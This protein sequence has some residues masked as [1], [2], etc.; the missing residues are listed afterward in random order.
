[1]K[2]GR[3]LRNIALVILGGIS[4]IV[5]VACYAPYDPE[6]G[7]EMYAPYPYPPE[8]A[9]IT[10]HDVDEEITLQDFSGQE[11][12]MTLQKD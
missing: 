9:I 6:P 1:M 3:I 5:L 7:P 2:T 11:V 4:Q 12:V 10:P 8:E